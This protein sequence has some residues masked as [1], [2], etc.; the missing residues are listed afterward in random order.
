LSN[1]S[2]RGVREKGGASPLALGDSAGGD[3]GAVKWAHE[4]NVLH[5]DIKPQNVLVSRA[6]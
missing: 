5:A 6:L 3:A 1:K 2:I 4:K